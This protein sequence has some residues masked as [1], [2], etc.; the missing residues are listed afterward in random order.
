V[1]IRVIA[2]DRLN[3]VKIWFNHPVW[4]QIIELSTQYVDQNN[5]SKEILEVIG[6][7]FYN[8]MFNFVMTKIDGAKFESF[9]KYLENKIPNTA[10]LSIWINDQSLI[11]KP[12]SLFIKI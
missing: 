10:G 6:N 1:L 2:Y 3:V 5:P 9:I 11:I 8:D 12:D 4:Y 7:G